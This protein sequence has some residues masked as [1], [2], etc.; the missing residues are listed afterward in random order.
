MSKIKCQKKTDSL[1]AME[2]NSELFTNKKLRE[3]LEECKFLTNALYSK[4]EELIEAN[5]ETR[6]NISNLSE[7]L[8]LVCKVLDIEDNLACKV[9]DVEE[10]EFKK[11]GRDK[12]SR[13]ASGYKTIPVQKKGGK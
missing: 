11:G 1:E 12:M 9:L 3:E 5:K 13:T 2:K 6:E 7:V 8:S 10:S 4:C